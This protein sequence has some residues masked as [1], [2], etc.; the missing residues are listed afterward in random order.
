MASTTFFFEDDSSGS[1]HEHWPED[2]K[3]APAVASPGYDT[4][5]GLRM[6]SYKPATVAAPSTV[7]IPSTKAA[8]PPP[9]LSPPS[10]PEKSVKAAVLTEFAV[11]YAYPP[12]EPIKMTTHTQAYVSAPAPVT[13]ALATGAPASVAPSAK[14]AAPKAS[15]PIPNTFVYEPKFTEKPAE[16]TNKWQGRTK[17]EVEEDN[18]KIA[19]DEKVWEKRKVVPTGLP[20]DRMCWVVEADASYTLR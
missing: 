18:T 19:A 16:P 2:F 7:A 17:A 8:S 5:N 20:D 1:E 11:Q 12:P 6:Y 9:S 13:A 4:Q 15:E 10:S 14:T 3:P